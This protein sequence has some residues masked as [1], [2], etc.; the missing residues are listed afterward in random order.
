[1]DIFSLVLELSIN[2]P[3]VTDKIPHRLCLCSGARGGG[4]VVKGVKL[5][6]ILIVAD[7]TITSSQDDHVGR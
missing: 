6:L 3:E 5:D 2:S 7:K 4:R 1:M